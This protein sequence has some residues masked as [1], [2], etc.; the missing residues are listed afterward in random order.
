M[1]EGEGR[2]HSKIPVRNL[3]HMLCYAW[4]I[5]DVSDD[6]FADGEEFDNIYN[7]FAKVYLKGVKT[8]LKQGKDRAYVTGLWEESGIRGKL[9]VRESISMMAKRSGIWVCERDEFSEDI[10]CNQIIKKTIRLLLKAPAVD[11]VLK[12]RL[13]ECLIRFQETADVDFSAGLL[14]KLRFQRCRRRYRMLMHISALLYFGLLVTETQGQFLFSDFI[15]DRQMAVLFEKFVLNFYKC[16]LDKRYHI[17][18]PRILWQLDAKADE[19]ELN[20]LPEM[21][22][23]I[24]VED[25]LFNTQLIIDTKYYAQTLVSSQWSDKEKIRNAHLNQLFAYMSNSTYEGKING[26]LLY[27]VVDRS[28]NR[29]FPVK[30][31]ML[32][33]HTVNL[34]DDWRNIE[35]SLLGLI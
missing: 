8:I 28:I 16:H 26:F 27:P 5:L 9:A 14:K 20:L 24:V 19:E 4:N 15:R 35:A 11:D 33:I 22:T 10:L 25:R 29:D 7:L 31:K 32:G 23:D 12:T 34:N 18:S 21:R 1:A 2:K 3:Y 30:G 17:Y 6:I 13:K